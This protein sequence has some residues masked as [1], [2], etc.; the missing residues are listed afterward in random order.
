MFQYPIFV[1]GLNNRRNMRDK[2]ACCIAYFV[3]FFATDIWD[4]YAIMFDCVQD[5]A[6]C[7]LNNS[8]VKSL[9]KK[10]ISAGRSTPFR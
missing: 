9:L 6:A 4:N 7:Y 8:I 5:A 3:G 2:P 10:S 1:N